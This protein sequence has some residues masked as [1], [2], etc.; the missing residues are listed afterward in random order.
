MH[1]ITIYCIIHM[2]IHCLFCLDLLQ[3]YCD[4]GNLPMQG[5]VYSC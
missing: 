1:C 2:I 5:N 3:I 4:E